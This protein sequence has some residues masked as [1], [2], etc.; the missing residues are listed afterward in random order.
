MPDGFFTTM[1]EKDLELIRSQFIG[2]ECIY[3]ELC[4]VAIHARVSGITADDSMISITMKSLKTPGFLETVPERDELRVSSA[5]G[6]DFSFEEELWRS[7]HCPWWIYFDPVMIERTIRFAKKMA[8]KKP[9]RRF[10]KFGSW[11]AE[12]EWQGQ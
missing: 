11:F 10:Q 4:R 9:E 5:F 6:I 1:N 3:F 8:S 12:Q 7:I 2:R